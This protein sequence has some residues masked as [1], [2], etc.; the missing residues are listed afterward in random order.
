MS[1]T[2]KLLN[3]FVFS[4]IVF[5]LL[6][7]VHRCNQSGIFA[8]LY[9]QVERANA[10]STGLEQ[11]K[12]AMSSGHAAIHLQDDM[13]MKNEQREQMSNREVFDTGGG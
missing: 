13:N 7:Y 5:S 2:E 4:N 12:D 3:G 6:Y 11:N 9:Q 1:F 8:S 10:G